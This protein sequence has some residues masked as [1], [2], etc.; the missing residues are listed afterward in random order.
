MHESRRLQAWLI[1]DVG[2][3]N[4]MRSL[5]LTF[6]LCFGS[7]LYADDLSRPEDHRI[8]VKIRHEKDS[9]G[10][11]YAIT[12]PLPA[13]PSEL[14]RVGIHGSAEL[15]FSVGRDGAVTD[16]KVV[17]AT[18][19]EFGDPAKEAVA[20]WRFRLNPDRP[21][22]AKVRCWIVFAMEPEE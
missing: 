7:I 22:P 9:P 12:M 2:R 13:Y 4:M 14:L 21:L 5:L 3:M 17:S 19:R 16:V 6:V 8:S 18:Q 11:A 1:F 10:R 15:T 20:R